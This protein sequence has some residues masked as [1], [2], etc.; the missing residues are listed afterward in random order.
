MIKVNFSPI[1][2]DEIT[3]ASL[4]GTVLT[5]NGVAFDLSEIP[6]GATV[7]HPVIM[8]AIREGDDYELTFNLTHGHNAPIETRFPKPLEIMD[9]NWALEYTYDVDR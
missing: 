1:R 2:G 7:K 8:E 9:S 4:D 6:D 5:I 3:T